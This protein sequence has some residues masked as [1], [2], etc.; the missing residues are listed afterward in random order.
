GQCASTVKKV[1]MELGGNAPFIVF[2]DADIDA[3][4]QGAMA[5]KYRNAGQ[6]CVCTNRIF[7]H[8]KVYP[9]FCQKFTAAVSQLKVGNGL[10]SGIT[11]G[12]MISA[13][14]VEDVDKLVKQS[15]SQGANIALG[16]K[17]HHAGKTF[18][19]PTVLT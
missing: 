17:P 18:Y 2:D 4:V 1:S 8:E 12:P 7:V 3:A 11:I 15:V 19:Q 14:A 16:G 9:V 13:S 6:T 5:S 10:T